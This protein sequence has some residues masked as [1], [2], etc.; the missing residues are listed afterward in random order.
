MKYKVINPSVVYPFDLTFLKDQLRITHAAHDNYLISLIAASTD[1]AISYTGRQMNYCT[2]Q[3]YCSLIDTKIKNWLSNY[4]IKEF[5]IDRGPVI[6]ISKV[7]YLNTSGQLVE[8]TSGDYSTFKENLDFQIVLNEQFNFVNPELFRKDAFR[9]TYTAGYGGS[10]AGAIS[11][12]DIIKNAI[13]MRAARLYANPD[14]GVDEKITVS[15][16]MLKSYQCQII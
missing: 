2:L 9:I 15:E 6:E 5:Q 16:N 10:A 7:E 4:P 13:A 14:D 3:A 1:W 12:P 8:I 11:F